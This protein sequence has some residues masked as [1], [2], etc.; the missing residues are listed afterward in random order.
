[1]NN[2]IGE[3]YYRPIS[4]EQEI[5]DHSKKNKLPLMLKGPTGCG[6]S[7][8]IEYC[9]NKNQNEL[10]T[11]SCNEDTSASDLIGR[12]I[13]KNNEVEWIDGPV[14]K[15]VRNGAILYLD[16]I[17]EAREDVTVLIH[18]L[19]DH[20]RTLFIDKT[21]EK[22]RA[23]ENFQLVIS[24]NPKYQRGYKQLKPSTAQR[25]VALNFD[26]PPKDIEIEIVANESSLDL[27]VVKKLVNFARHIRTLSEYNLA[28][29]ASTRLIVNAAK[30]IH[31]GVSE[32]RAVN[33]CIINPLSEDNDIISSLNDLANLKF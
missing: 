14:S 21:N 17:T 20:R 8:F 28:E 16:E 31:S 4:F 25:F 32:R 29:S 24:Y 3:V 1:M 15:A 11:V 27:S 9:A 33:V 23:P 12:Y 18:S 5:F 10:I 30:M 26:Y 6:K 7:R 13:L 2:K 22:L 19:T